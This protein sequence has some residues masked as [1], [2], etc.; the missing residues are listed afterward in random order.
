MTTPIDDLA[1]KLTSEDIAN[2]KEVLDSQMSLD[3]SMT[4]MPTDVLA[5]LLDAALAHAA[6]EKLDDD[7][8]AWGE[9]FALTGVEW[10]HEVN[11]HIDHEA[12]APVPPDNSWLALEGCNHPDCRTGRKFEAA[13][14]R[15]SQP[16]ATKEAGR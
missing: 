14:A 5:R 9:R 10:L 16:V 8:R 11:H 2:V 7:L 3:H 1:G 4:L 12:N 6:P 13:L 15:L